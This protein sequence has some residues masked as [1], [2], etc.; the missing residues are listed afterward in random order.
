MEEIRNHLMPDRNRQY[1]V[2]QTG[3]RRGYAVPAILEQAGLLDSFHTDVCGNT[4]WGAGLVAL[5]S[6]FGIG[7][8]IRLLAKRKVP[9]EVVGKTHTYAVP[10]LRW[11]ARRRLQRPGAEAEFR[12]HMQR[13]LETGDE[14]VRQGLGRATHLYVMYSEFPS[15]M[16][17]VRKQGLKVVA[18]VFIL[19]STNAILRKERKL[20]PGWEEEAPDW[21]AISAEMSGE[22]VL[23]TQ[24]DHYICP[25]EAVRQDLIENWGVQAGKTAVVPYGMSPA[26]LELKPEPVRGRLFFAGTADLRKGIHYLAMAAEELKR[27]GRNYEFR[28]AGHVTDL[29]RHRPECQ[30][31]T[32][33]GRVSRDQIQNEYRQ[34]DVFVL[35]TLAEGSAEVTYEAMA[36]GLPLVTTLAAGSVAR[37]GVEALI[38]PER[39]ALA[40]ADALECLVEDRELRSRLSAAARARAAEYTWDFYGGRLTRALMSFE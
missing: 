22:D 8:R 31:L 24:V 29:V 2:A 23:F 5:A 28:V 21:D 36:C 11:A 4:G 20:F 33:L 37:D 1:M 25:S 13:V 30:N 7:G 39:N 34:A 26:W 19:H 35:P 32:F 40:L 3:A 14:I 15:L 16:R 10:S 18:E 9:E 6:C 12:L 38:V 17:E 27:R